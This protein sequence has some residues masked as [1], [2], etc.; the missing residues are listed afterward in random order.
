MT[1]EYFGGAGKGKIRLSK[2]NTS[3][4]ERMDIPLRFKFFLRRADNREIEMDF[5]FHAS[6]LENKIV[7]MLVQVYYQS[8]QVSIVE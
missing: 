6:L 5:I 4:I 1:G 2:T 3:S 8:E 7:G